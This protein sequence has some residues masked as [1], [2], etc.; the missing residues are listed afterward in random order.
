M[1]ATL[2]Q[3]RIPNNVDLASDKRLQRA[4]EAW[5]PSFLEWWREMGPD[6]FQEDLVY[7]RTAVGVDPDG[8]AHFDYV[9]MPDY[10]WGIFL[11]EAMPERAIGFGDHLGEPVWREV[12]GEHRNA[13][14]RILVTQADT[15]P[16]SVE[17]QR[18]LGK[19][20]P[21][22]Y[23]LRNLFQVNVEEG[24][25]LWAIAY[26]L[27]CHL[28]RD[29]REEA[30]E[31]LHRRSGDANKPR[32]LGAFNQPIE[33]WLA[34]FFFTFFT[35]RDGKF[36]LLALAE[37]GFDPLSRTARFMLTEEAHHMF[38]GESGIMRVVDRTAQL[39]RESG[40]DHPDDVRRLGGVDLPTVQRYLN[41]WFS[42][43][44]DL[45][46]GEVSSNAA[47]F[48][49]AGLKGRAYEARYDDH[50]ALEGTYAVELSKEGRV[51][52]EEVALRNAMNEV[53]R[54]AYVE[55]CQ[56]GVDRWNKAI[57]ARGIP[58]QLRLPSRRFHR[59]IGVHA[60][61]F[62]DP[63][64]NLLPEAEW[65]ARRGEWLPGDADRA[66]LRS[67]GQRPVM[68]PGQMAGWIAAP[69][70]GIKGRPAEFEYVRREG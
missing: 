4:L 61:L 32:I 26:L 44:L 36:Q 7:L 57:A 42:V 62:A 29:G 39:M 19:S 27:H 63:A 1:T 11:A 22:V 35:D 33:D 17:Q 15:E 5:Q 52:R 65:R 50:R 25:H 53:L 14:R 48:F 51:V 18:L 66:F 13:L 3:D 43:S 40:K 59:A 23:D 54:D 41:L 38:V 8:W 60:G 21:S 68:D 20:C 70:Q 31:L 55:D 2:A 9:K 49:A 30:E 69:K 46:G 10:R 16:A 45:F 67:L 12:P 28:G 47:A 24:R 6:G 56:R 58:F 64:G 34:F 37:S